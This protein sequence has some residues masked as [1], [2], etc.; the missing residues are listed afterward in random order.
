MKIPNAWNRGR[1]DVAAVSGRADL[2]IRVLV[3]EGQASGDLI[4]VRRDFAW[5]HLAKVPVNYPNQVNAG[6]RVLHQVN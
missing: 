3:L 5:C 2:D 4:N 6:N 1:P